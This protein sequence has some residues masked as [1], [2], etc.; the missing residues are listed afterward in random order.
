VSEY[1]YYGFLAID[2]KLDATT[3][4]ALRE[5]SSRARITATRFIAEYNYGDFPGDPAK[6]LAN[7]FDLHVYSGFWSSRQFAMRLPKQR[8]DRAAIEAFG[9]DDEFLTIEETADAL[10][11]QVNLIEW[12]IDYSS[13]ETG[14][15]NQ[16]APLRAAVLSGDLRCFYLLWLMQ[17]DFE[18][19]VAD[20]A[21]EPLAGI[22][23]LNAALEA[24]A[25]FLNINPDLLEAAAET[26]PAAASRHRSAGE[27]RE[28]MARIVD[29]REQ[30]ELERQAA[31]EVERLAREA[32]L[33]EQRR[34]LLRARGD[35]VWQDIE[36][37]IERNRPI[38]FE[39][40]IALM[41]DLL[42][43]GIDQAQ[44]RRR[45]ADIRDRHASKPRF[46][47]RL[48]SAGLD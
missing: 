17:V 23:P 24:F 44:F 26:A 43:I 38:G 36:A 19:E 34:A 48:D 21:A 22:G 1:Q 14:W 37:E 29:V 16:L 10:I 18:D 46:I 35:A 15:L 31:A 41:A 30:L 25:D 42:E 12:D 3:R 45:L 5:I 4:Q 47:K 8:V 9:I 32:E 40:A 13:D 27:L 33:E 2:R 7:W 28:A 20:D 39:Q 11:V 6:L